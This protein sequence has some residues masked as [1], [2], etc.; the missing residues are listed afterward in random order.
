MYII[1]VMQDLNPGTNNR[2]TV[3]DDYNWGEPNE[4]TFVSST[5]FPHEVSHPIPRPGRGLRRHTSAEVQLATG[6][7]WDRATEMMGENSV[8][9]K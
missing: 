4:Y 7:P 6:A 3:F 8:K 1:N 5:G 2:F 9:D